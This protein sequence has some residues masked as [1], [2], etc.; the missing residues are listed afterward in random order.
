MLFLLVIAYAIYFFFFKSFAYKLINP[1]S[2]GLVI[3]KQIKDSNPYLGLA[4][5]KYIVDN[6]PYIMGSGSMNYFKTKSF[7]EKLKANGAQAEMIIPFI[8]KKVAYGSL[9]PIDAAPR[10]EQH[11]APEQEPCE[12]KSSKRAY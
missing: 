8:W 7:V 1:G 4:D 12:S 2:N 10:Q 5:A 3:V 9:A 6:T 11:H